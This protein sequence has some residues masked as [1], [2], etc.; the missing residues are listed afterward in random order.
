MDVKLRQLEE[1]LLEE[2][3]Q[4]GSLCSRAKNNG[5]VSGFGS[6]ISQKKTFKN[7]SVQKT[8]KEA[9]SGL[10]GFVVVYFFTNIY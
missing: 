2:E 10:V 4:E 7:C 5:R 3:L 1:A 8:L 9:V 6:F